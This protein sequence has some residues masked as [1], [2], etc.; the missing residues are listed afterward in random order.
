MV[1]VLSKLNSGSELM[2]YVLPGTCVEGRYGAGVQVWFS[3][4]EK[5]SDGRSVGAGDVLADNPADEA[6]FAAV[7]MGVGE[8]RTWPHCEHTA[9]WST[10]SCGVCD[11]L[12]SLYI[13]VSILLILN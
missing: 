6:S 7:E 5:L 9:Q 13:F 11:L 3:E 12:V 10:A 1:R 4:V 8:D 2:S